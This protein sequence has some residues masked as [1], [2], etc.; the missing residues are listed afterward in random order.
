MTLRG[1]KIFVS[2][3][4]GVIGRSLVSRLRELGAVLFVGDLEPR[5]AGWSPDV[6]YR[7]GDLNDLEQWELDRFYPD[8]V[9]HLAATFE[10]SVETPEFWG[11]NYRHNIELSHHLLNICKNVPTIKRLIFASS[12]LIY[13]PEQYLFDAPQNEGASL[14]EESAINPRNL[15]GAAKLLHETELEFFSNTV[16]PSFSTVSARIFRSYGRGSRDVIS[17]WVRAALADQPIQIFN[18]GGMFDY[19]FAD[20][21][22][23]GLIRLVSSQFT[24]VVNLGRGRARRVGEVVDTLRERFPGLVVEEVDSAPPFESSKADMSRFAAVANWQP[25]TDIEHGIAAIIEHERA[26][27][28]SEER[29]VPAV[30]VT[31]ISSKVGCLKAVRDALNRIGPNGQLFGADSNDDCIARHFV[32]TFWLMPPLDSFEVAELIEYCRSHDITAV[33]PTRDGELPFFARHRAELESAG[34]AIMVSSP[35]SIDLCIDKLAFAQ[36]L[37]TAGYPVI[38]AC[39]R[40]ED[41]N[42]NRVVVKERFGAGSQGVLVNVDRQTAAKEIQRFQEPL[43]QPFIQGQEYSIDTFTPRTGG[44]MAAVARRRDMVARGESQLT[45]AVNAPELEHLC[46]EMSDHFGLYGHAVW[47][48]LEDTQGNYHV[49][50]CNARFGGA[51]TL[52]IAMGV[53]SFFWF[54]CDACG[55]V[56][57]NSGF[58]RFPVNLRQI[59]I[60]YDVIEPD[61]DI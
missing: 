58:S 33:I 60:P 30:L 40:I 5:P 8:Y 35:N 19:V 15:C 28:V 18:A 12:Y 52:G 36:R 45:T 53:D 38:P 43:I 39:Q 27:I 56:A 54:L 37:E 24:G 61:P 26:A 34:I 49:I 1:K 2:G 59:R 11:E 21:V 25:D 48:A 57:A 4:A 29:M 47:Q 32:D 3:G 31:S 9:F 23:E 16:K 44:T 41:C 22:A 50:E 46:R 20:D 7:Q 13:D 14:S 55:T 42:A 17:R 6:L 51:S 10:R